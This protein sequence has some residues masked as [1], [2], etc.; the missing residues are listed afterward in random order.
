MSNEVYSF[1]A[2]LFGRWFKERGILMCSALVPLK[3]EEY[4][5]RTRYIHVERGIFT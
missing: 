3:D 5:C 2:R 4:S 1:V